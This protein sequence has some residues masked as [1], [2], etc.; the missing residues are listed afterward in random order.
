MN[1][2]ESSTHSTTSGESFGL[3]QEDTSPPSAQPSGL[4]PVLASW[5]GSLANEQG[6]TMRQ[7]VQNILTEAW[8]RSLTDSPEATNQIL[9]ALR[10]MEV[11]LGK[12]ISN[13]HD[14]ILAAVRQDVRSLTHSVLG[15][16]AGTEDKLMKNAGPESV[17][18]QESVSVIQ[19]LTTAL[20]RDLPS[21][22]GSLVGMGQQLARMHQ[23]LRDQPSPAEFDQRL[24]SLEQKID[25]LLLLQPR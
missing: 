23:A 20:N 10:E 9:D 7:A 21:L 15:R 8:R 1:G 13:S 17:I 22:R 18:V 3:E 11:W 2:I 25:E 6:I 16:L 24:Q 4:P 14:G 5:L 19:E 12:E